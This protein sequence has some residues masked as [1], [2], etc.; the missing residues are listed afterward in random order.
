MNIE[1]DL[2]PV[3]YGTN[4]YGIKIDT[5]VFH[6][7]GGFFN[8][9]R[10][11]FKN[12]A[13]QVSCHYLI[14]KD[15]KILRMVEEKNRAWH[16][17]SYNSRSIGIEL[18]DE[19]KGSEWKYTPQQIES[20]K[21]LVKD[22]ESRHGKL[23]YVLHRNISSNRSDPVGD[24]NLE[25]ITNSTQQPMTNQDKKDIESMRALREYNNVWYESK[26][27]IKDYEDR[28]QEVRDLQDTVSKKSEVISKQ[29]EQL[30]TMRDEKREAIERAEKAEAEAKQKEE[31]RAKW[32]TELQQ[33][34]KDME[35][36]RDQRDKCGIELKKEQAK[37]FDLAK[38]T[39]RDL[40]MELLKR[41]I[42]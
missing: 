15:G 20:L 10:S 3:N 13:S 5:I 25:W 11:W 39:R 38:A 32:Y 40:I 37:N 22:I 14:G 6:S 7:M 23:N 4:R 1:D 29:S 27:I 17:G 28:K 31:L 26:N 33:A 42:G 41:F 12:P 24:F 9:T 18:E 36:V 19:E 34:K 30:I 21:F 2:T 35:F 8:G 16:A